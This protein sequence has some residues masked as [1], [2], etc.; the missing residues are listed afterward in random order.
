MSFPE[1]TEWPFVLA[2]QS[3]GGVLLIRVSVKEWRGCRDGGRH[4]P[5]NVN[6]PNTTKMHVK[7][8]KIASISCELATVLSFSPLKHGQESGVG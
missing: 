5:D 3:G 7:T 8:I 1:N 4:F 2:T 6:K